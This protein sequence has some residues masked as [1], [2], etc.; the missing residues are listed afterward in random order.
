M[1]APAPSLHA[2]GIPSAIAGTGESIRVPGAV[3]GRCEGGHARF[4]PVLTPS[5]ALG[6]RR[7]S[8]LPKA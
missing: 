7:P 5:V 6:R 2:P 8:K 3:A 4:G 1:H